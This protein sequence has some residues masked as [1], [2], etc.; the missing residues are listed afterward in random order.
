MFILV[1]AILVLGSTAVILLPD[2][3]EGRW[4]K[5]VIYFVMIAT[6]VLLVAV[7]V[8]LIFFSKAPL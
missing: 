5:R 3:P 7:V 4:A 8:G 1:V 2:S 6:L